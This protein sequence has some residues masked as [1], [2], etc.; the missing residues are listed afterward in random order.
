MKKINTVNIIGLGA[1]GMLYG[2]SLTDALGYENVCFVMDSVRLD[3]YK[4]A[5]FICNG[6]KCDFHM[7]T[8]EEAKPVDLVIIAVKYPGLPE[9][10]DIM[11]SSIGPDTIIMSVMN[12]ISSEEIIAERYGKDNIIY[13]V[14]QGMDAVK[15]GGDLTFSQSGELHIGV[16]EGQDKACL[17][18]VTDVL[19]RSSLDYV[20]EDDIMYRMWGKFMLNVGVNQTCMVYD[21][22]YRGIIDEGEPNLIFISAM[23]EVIAVANAEGINL[24]ESD[25][26]MYVDIIKTLNPDKMPSM[27]QDRINKK[28]GEVDAFSGILIKLAK[29]HDIHVPVNRFLNR[30]AK[31]IEKEYI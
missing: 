25:L 29:K 8:P 24:S 28:P 9:A 6:E 21:T 31:E 14:A 22:T 11:K 23:R 10:I 26:N 3:K 1:L 12:G 20:I 15:F 17:E 7:I 30:R 13:T 4:D 19:R 18:P 16:P 5:D 27:A 2:K